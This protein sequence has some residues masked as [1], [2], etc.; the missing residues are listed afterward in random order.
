MSTC[1]SCIRRISGNPIP[2]HTTSI[3]KIF[4]PTNYSSICN[5]I[6]SNV[7][8]VVFHVCK[9]HFIKLF[10][11]PN[12]RSKCSIIHHVHDI[13]INTAVSSLHI[14]SLVRVF[15]MTHVNVR[16]W[17]MTY[18]CEVTN[19]IYT[20]SINFFTHINQCCFRCYLIHFPCLRFL[21]L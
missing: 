14:P 6:V 12:D 1:M 15:N 20:F 18:K 10:S 2:S 9:F 3:R 4:Y 17:K 16:I 19:L 7:V 13:V 11:K 5:F 21:S 8:N